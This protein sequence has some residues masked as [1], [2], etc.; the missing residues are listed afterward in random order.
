[1]LLFALG[2]FEQYFPAGRVFFVAGQIPIDSQAGLFSRP[3]ALQAPDE[4]F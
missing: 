4:F 3:G 1:M 2:Q